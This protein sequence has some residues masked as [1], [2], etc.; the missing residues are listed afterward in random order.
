M[1]QALKQ[2]PLEAMCFYRICMY[3]CK[4][5]PWWERDDCGR[6]GDCRGSQEAVWTEAAASDDAVVSSYVHIA[7]SS[8]AKVL[9]G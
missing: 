3:D 5:A 6:G 1:L 4:I 7:W 2:S 8:E 9:R